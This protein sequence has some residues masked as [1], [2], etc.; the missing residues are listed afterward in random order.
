MKNI[1]R[2]FLLLAATALFVVACFGPWDGDKELGTVTISL[3]TSSAARWAA[4]AALISDFTHEIRLIRNG[5]LI[6]TETVQFNATSHTA[7]IQ[8]SPGPIDVEVKA[9]LSGWDIAEGHSTATVNVVAGQTVQVPMSNMERMDSGVVFGMDKDNFDCGTVFQG[10]SG[11]K[12][13][14]ITNYSSTSPLTLT[15]S[16]PAGSVFAA[17][18]PGSVTISSQDTPQTITLSFTA[19]AT[20]TGDFQTITETITINDGAA[21]LAT[22]DAKVVVC[23]YTSGGIAKMIEEDTTGTV[24]VTPPDGT[25]T[26]DSTITINKTVNIGNANNP[27]GG[28]VIFKRASGFTS[29]SLFNVIA[30]GLLKVGDICGTNNPIIL[31]GD[32]ILA[33]KSLVTVNGGS[34]ELNDALNGGL[35]ILR[36][37]NS[38]QNGGAVSVLSGSFTMSFGLITSNNAVGGAGGGVYIEDGGS[39]AMTNGT[40]ISNTAS[41]GTGAGHAV[42]Y[43]SSPPHYRDSDVTSSNTNLSTSNLPPTPGTP[44]NNWDG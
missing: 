8:V 15:F 41:A 36:F 26:L 2:V 30:G 34:F 3:S 5:N 17:A 16:F 33:D 1:I 37:N 10:K 32:N 21:T 7:S 20:V 43:N 18:T 24:T 38:Y 9:K 42:Y 29:G 25:Y 22:F 4:P 14:T 31:D 23:N 35:G 27:S 11:S 40:I 44:G 39:F 6:C 19:P 12:T 13:I 28:S